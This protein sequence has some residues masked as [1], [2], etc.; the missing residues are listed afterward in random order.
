[1][2]MVMNNDGSGGLYQGNSLA[3]AV[4]W[5]PDLRGRNLIGNVDILVTNPPFGS[6]IRI[7]DPTILEQYDLA[8]I[9][10]YD[11][12]DD[13]YR[14]RV[15][16]TLMRAQPPE[17]LFIERCVQLLRPGIGQMAIVVPDAILGAPGLA[18][19]REWILQ[20]TEVLASVDLHPDTFQPKNSTQT[21]ILVL[22]RKS[23][24][25]I[26]IEK[27]SG[28]KRD[29]EVFLALADH[30]GHDKRGNE[31]Y[32]RDSEGN[33]VVETKHERVREIHNGVTVLKNVERRY[34]LVDDTTLR[35]AREF[36]AWL[37]RR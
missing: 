16:R 4:T 22:R 21:S 20:Q 23:A 3:R 29:Y 9:W 13:T 11:E 35:I 25:E 17:I 31:T 15:P 32:V 19:V 27:A 12:A 26:E 33:E 18:Y 7:E 24:S 8:H 36:R 28:R 6:R 1:M 34:R 10:N 14:L 2:N 37:D 5:Q 30:V